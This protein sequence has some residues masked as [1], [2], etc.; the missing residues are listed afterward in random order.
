MK[1]KTKSLLLACMLAVGSMGAAPAFAAHGVPLNTTFSASGATSL[2]AGG[3]TVACTST[4]TLV[5]GA[6]VANNTTVTQAVFTG[7]NPICASLTAQGLPWQ[8][9]YNSTTAATIQ[10]VSIR[11]PLTT[12]AGNVSAAINSAASSITISGNVG[13]GCTASGVLAV[14]PAFQVITPN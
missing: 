7:S 4:F 13:S 1:V 8:V 5:S 14:S 10:N 12:C 2:T 9:T 3:I 11:T 6:N